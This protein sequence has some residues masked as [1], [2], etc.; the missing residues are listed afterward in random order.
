MMMTAMSVEGERF[1]MVE[2]GDAEDVVL[3]L[4]TGRALWGQGDPREAVRWLRRA[5]EHAEESGN[6]MRALSLARTAADLAT[7]MQSPQTV[8]VP[9]RQ[10]PFADSTEPDALTPQRGA[11]PKPPAPPER[12]SATASK[13]PPAPSDLGRTSSSRMPVAKPLTPSAP[14]VA[15]R[16]PAANGAGLSSGTQRASL[17]PAP[18]RPSSIPQRPSSV[19]PKPSAVTQKPPS[20]APAV[21]LPSRPS[22]A[23]RPGATTAPSPVLA[24]ANARRRGAVRVAVS[25]SRDGDESILRVQILDDGE[26]VP[27]GSVEALIVPLD[28]D[29]DLLS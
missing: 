7:S 15:P 23:P 22:V 20:V 11:L 27:S 4:E 17:P 3:A 26:S 24:H 25:K 13:R 8:P 6:D 18:A 2:A 16:P 1:P 21:P 5:A 19:T 29:A 14:P 9:P 10:E 28:P 12:S